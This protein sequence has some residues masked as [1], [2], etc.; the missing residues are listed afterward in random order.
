MQ[1]AVKFILVF[2]DMHQ[3][4]YAETIFKKSDGSQI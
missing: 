2:Q 1:I 4:L 3:F